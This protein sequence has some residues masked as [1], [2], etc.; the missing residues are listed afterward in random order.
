MPAWCSS[1]VSVEIDLKAKWRPGGEPQ[2]AQT[3]VLVDVVEIVVEA[4]ALS[5]LQESVVRGLVVPRSEGGTRLHGGKDMYQTGMIPSLGNDPF[6]T[7][8]LA[9][10]FVTTDKFYLHPAALDQTRSMLPDF[11]TNP[12]GTP[13]IVKNPDLVIAEKTR[14]RPVVSDI[15]QSASDYHPVKTRKHAANGILVSFDKWIHVRYPRL[16]HDGSKDISFHNFLV[17]A[18]LG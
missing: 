16:D 2:I 6:N 13:G 5:S 14:H 17:P 8:F 7:F 15:R 11:I 9:K 1:G 4:L 18:M 3:E 10:S 12:V